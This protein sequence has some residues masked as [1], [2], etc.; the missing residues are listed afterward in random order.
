MWPGIKA[1]MP[2]KD[3]PDCKGTGE[4]LLFNLSSKC[5]SCNGTGKKE[6]DDG[7][8]IDCIAGF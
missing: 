2:K 4:I 6:E 8:S 1:P 5:D 7:F 3:C